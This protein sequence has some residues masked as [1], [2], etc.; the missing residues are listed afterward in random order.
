VRSSHSVPPTQAPNT[1]R[2]SLLVASAK[3]DVGSPAASSGGDSAVDV[4]TVNCALGTLDLG[5][6]DTASM[7]D[8]P[9]HLRERPL[10]D[11]FRV[12]KDVLKE[13]PAF[14]VGWKK[15]SW[16]VVIREQDIGIF[17]SIF[18]MC[19]EWYNRSNSHCHYDFAACQSFTPPGAFV[20]II[21]SL[22]RIITDL[23][24]PAVS[25]H[26][27]SETED[28]SMFLPS[29]SPADY[30]FMFTFPIKT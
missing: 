25:R 10:Y 15:P 6:P 7:L 14:H 13:Y 17:F 28:P 3:V 12:S 4:S 26:D 30:P 24:S 27:L 18:G 1:K 21:L 22:L 20:S 29:G 8:L 19:S 16:V 9:S 2:T 23:P 5:K 11:Q